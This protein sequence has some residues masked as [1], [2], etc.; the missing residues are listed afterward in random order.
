MPGDFAYV[1]ARAQARHGDRLS[2]SRWRAVEASTNLGGYIHALMG[3]SLA[4]AV[5]HFTGSASPHAIERTLRVT[6]RSEV[7]RASRWV[8]REWRDSVAW[9]VWLPDLDAIGFLLD[10]NAILPWMHEDSLLTQ[11]AFEQVDERRSAIQSQVGPLPPGDDFDP[12]KWWYEHWLDRLPTAD[13]RGTGLDELTRHLEA[14]GKTRWES[15]ASSAAMIETLEALA[16]RI[17]RLL[18]R[19]TG[20]PVSVFCHLALTALELMRLRGGLVRHSLVNAGATGVKL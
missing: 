6:W 3:T 15:V 18:R 9:A 17:T 1:Q 4:P 8:P 12:G 19:R 5:R 20:K 10:G 14:F 16:E 13:L 11:F 7:E 2:P